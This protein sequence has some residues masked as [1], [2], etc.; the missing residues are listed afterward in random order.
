MYFPGHPYF[1]GDPRPS[2][3]STRRP[4]E[5][6]HLRGLARKLYLRKGVCLSPLAEDMNS[7]TERGARLASLTLDPPNCDLR[8]KQL[9]KLR[10]PSIQLRQ[11][12]SLSFRV[13]K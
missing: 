9:N 3:E 10:D 7:S 13:D 6:T 5:C 8:L 4:S 2:K 11:Y 12:Q 1:P